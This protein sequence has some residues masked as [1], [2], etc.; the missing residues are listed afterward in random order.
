MLERATEIYEEKKSDTL[1]VSHR[2]VRKM[3]EII[4]TRFVVQCIVSLEV[5][6]A[7]NES[8][9]TCFVFLLFRGVSLGQ[10]DVM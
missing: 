6:L 4:L 5:K 10:G 9:S 7:Q 2:S 3:N 8:K 1:E